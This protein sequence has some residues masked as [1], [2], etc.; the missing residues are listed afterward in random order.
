[1]SE[2]ESDREYYAR[3]VNCDAPLSARETVEVQVHV[4][5]EGGGYDR[6][7]MPACRR[8]WLDRHGVECG[9][10]GEL[11]RTN[12]AAYNCCVGK[13]KAPDCAECGRRMEVGAKG[14]GPLEGET[15]TWAECECCPVGWGRYTGWV[16]TD[17]EP[18]KHV[19]GDDRDE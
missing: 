1:M 5:R 12:E 13:S 9:H 7:P 16:Q 14:Y 15:I 18:C 10:C 11:H 2:T 8:C 4:D 6:I 17:G 19:E 3:C